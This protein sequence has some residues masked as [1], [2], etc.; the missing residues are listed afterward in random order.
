MEYLAVRETAEKWNLSARHRLRLR[1]FSD[2]VEFLPFDDPVEQNVQYLFCMIQDE[3]RAFYI[4][5]AW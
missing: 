1:F 3:K 2:T 4:F 5:P